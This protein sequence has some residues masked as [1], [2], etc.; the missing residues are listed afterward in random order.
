M[1]LGMKY[2]KWTQLEEREIRKVYQAHHWW[3]RRDLADELGVTE[4]ALECH[5]RKMKKDGRL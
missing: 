5:I 1:K 2:H 4:A 3:G